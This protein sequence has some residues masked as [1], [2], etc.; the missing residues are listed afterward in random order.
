MIQYE[1]YQ[2]DLLRDR[3]TELSSDISESSI[4]EKK[5]ENNKSEITL[6]S[7]F[8]IVVAIMG[9]LF[10]LIPFVGNFMGLF[11]GIILT[12]LYLFNGSG[13]KRAQRKQATRWILIEGAYLIEIFI[14]IIGF[15]PLFT[16][17]A[18]VDFVLTKKGYYEKIGKITQI[19]N[20]LK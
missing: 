10:G 16:L 13:K 4:S 14:P 19:A 8:I 1:Q 17:E 15:L 6:L 20:K 9:D 18:V 2:E 3:Q 5:E 7:Y 11:F 12:M